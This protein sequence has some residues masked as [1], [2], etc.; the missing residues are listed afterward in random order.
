MGCIS[1]IVTPYLNN[2]DTIKVAVKDTGVG[3]KDELKKK[4]FSAF[5]KGKSKKDKE[6]N[7]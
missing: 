5:S 2:K 7:P 1:I 3:M 6:L 4:L